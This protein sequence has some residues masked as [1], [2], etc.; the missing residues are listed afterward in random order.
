MNK[1]FIDTNVLF[2]GL[3]SA[4][5]ASYKIL[6]LDASEQLSLVISTP[7]LLECEDVLKRNQAKLELSDTEIEIVLDNLCNIS[8]HQKVYF[9]WR[10]FLPDPKDD[11]L[12]ELAVAVRRILKSVSWV[13]HQETQL[14]QRPTKSKIT[15]SIY[16]KLRGSA[17]TSTYLTLFVDL[18]YSIIF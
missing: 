16:L 4:R 5:G 15:I 17:N 6:Y 3:Y 1:I 14:K 11:L 9:L 18:I 8:R 2:A 13:E 10:P 12:L 7:I